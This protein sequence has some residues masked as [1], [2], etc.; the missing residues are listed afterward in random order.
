MNENYLM[1]YGIKTQEW[2]VR[3][4]QEKG[5]S[6]RTPE[7]KIRYAHSDKTSSEKK[8]IVD[9]VPQ[10]SMKRLVALKQRR[11]SLHRSLKSRSRIPEEER[12]DLVRQYEETKSAYETLLMNQCAALHKDPDSINFAYDSISEAV[13][14]QI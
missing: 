7:G 2:G 14:R 8:K 5:S 10:R 6:K 12:K 4:F 3:R 1:H 13:D 9:K 11:N